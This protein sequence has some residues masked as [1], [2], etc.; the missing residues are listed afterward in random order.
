MD[1]SRIIEKIKKCLALSRSANEHEAATALRQAQKLMQQYQIE[2][3]DVDMSDIAEYGIA[4]TVARKPA[5]WE[6]NLMCAISEAFGCELV[7]RSFRQGKARWVF[8]GGAVEVEVACYAA[9]VLRRQVIAARKCYM[10]ERLSRV[11]KVTLKT[12][13]ADRFCDGWVF[14]ATKLLG[15]YQRHAA[16]DSY[17]QQKRSGLAEL[18]VRDRKKIAG[19]GGDMDLLRGLAEG[20]S[21][22]LHDGV[23]AGPQ[24]KMIGA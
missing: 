15:R 1:K 10:T 4:A 13:R 23:S 12:A 14:S 21:A 17:M 18:G 22:Q 20:K 6:N 3:S 2:M 8:I 24:R 11:Q 7:F 16:L 9:D 19:I 5:C